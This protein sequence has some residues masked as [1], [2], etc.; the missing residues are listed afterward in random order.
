ME[1][2]LLFAAVAG[3]GPMWFFANRTT[4]PEGL[5]DRALG[6]VI[7]GLFVGRLTAMVGVGINPLTA[8]GDILIIRGGVST[9]GATSGALGYLAWTGRKELGPV[10]SGLAAPALIGLAGWHAGCVF[11]A[12]CSGSQA[13]WGRHPTEL[14]AAVLFLAGAALAYRLRTRLAD[15]TVGGGALAFAAAVRLGTEPIRPSLTGGPKLA[16]AVGIGAGLI[17]AAIGVRLAA[18]STSD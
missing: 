17:I 3:V 11:R 14:Y 15:L 6:A 12:A 16:Y 2:T 5:G 13:S 10:I 18:H 9:I 1:F 8:I 4:A 7:T